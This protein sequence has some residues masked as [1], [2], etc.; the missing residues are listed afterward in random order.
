MC[1]SGKRTRVTQRGRFYNERGMTEGAYR[2]KR[3]N[4]NNSC[5]P[6]CSHF[7]LNSLSLS[8]IIS[9]HSPLLVLSL[10]PLYLTRFSLPSPLALFYHFSL[11]LLFFSVA[12]A[13]PSF[14]FSSLFFFLF[15]FFF[16]F[17]FFVLTLLLV[18][19]CLFFFSQILSLLFRSEAYFFGISST[20]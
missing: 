11:F 14:L 20:A 18:F 10:F 1:N 13:L 12:T 7:F 16:F 8:L 6:L 3:N 4:K 5:L 15:F 2:E 19:F 9:I 17:F